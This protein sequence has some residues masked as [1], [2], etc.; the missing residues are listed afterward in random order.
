M[1]APRKYGLWITLL[2][3]TAMIAGCGIKPGRLDQPPGT[4][5]NDFPRDYPQPERD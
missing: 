5:P 3:T 2:A 4:E 1:T